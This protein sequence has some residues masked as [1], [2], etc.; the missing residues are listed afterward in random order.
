MI[1][2]TLSSA[3]VAEEFCFSMTA[4]R[5]LA[6]ARGSG[7]GD[8]SGVST[9]MA[10]SAP[11]ARAVRRTSTDLRGPIVMALIE[12]TEALRRSRRRTAS[13]IAR[14]R[15]GGKNGI[16][17]TVQVQNER[18]KST[19]L[20]KRVLFERLCFKKMPCTIN[21]LNKKVP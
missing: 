20:V 2:S 21:A 11:M 6:T 7:E 8:D 13:S 18:K 17:Q 4:R 16:I 1:K 14:Y 5:I 3:F 19:N 15:G 9:W 10:E 12:F